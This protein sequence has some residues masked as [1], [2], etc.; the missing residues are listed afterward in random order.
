MDKII[1]ADGDERDC[2]F[3]SVLSK[4][5]IAYIAIDTTSYLEAAQVFT[6]TSK[7]ETMQFGDYVIEGFTN[8]SYI[9]QQD[10]GMKVCM[11]RRYG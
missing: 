7:T 11:E 1:F 4:E 8:L 2:T 5:G 9:M 6:N 3:F 10:F